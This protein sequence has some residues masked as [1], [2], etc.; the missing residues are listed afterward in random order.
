[1]DEL[2]GDPQFRQNVREIVKGLRG[3]VSSTQQLQAQMQVA[4]SLDSLAPAENVSTTA[5]E[6]QI[7]VMPNFD[8]AEFS[9]AQ[10]TLKPIAPAAIEEESPQAQ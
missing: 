9:L 8:S 10:K 6:S 3:L 7:A 2:T 4:E 1:L 5:D